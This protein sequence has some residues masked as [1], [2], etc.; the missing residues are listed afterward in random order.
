MMP[1]LCA[2]TLG[3]GEQHQAAQQGGDWHS[4]HGRV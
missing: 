1:E 3:L 4:E 2:L